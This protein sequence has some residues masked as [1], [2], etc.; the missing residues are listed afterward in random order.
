MAAS[1]DNCLEKFHFE[2]RSKTSG[3]GCE[4]QKVFLLCAKMCLNAIG[5]TREDEEMEHKG[6]RIQSVMSGS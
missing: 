2:G 3:E 1:V 6:K 5:K 4:V